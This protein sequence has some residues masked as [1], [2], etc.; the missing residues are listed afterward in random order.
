[1][2]ALS[3]EMI[4]PLFALPKHATLGN[5]NA[6]LFTLYILLHVSL[7]LV[8]FTYTHQGLFL[9]LGL[10]FV[11]ICLGITLGYHRL[12][13]HRSYKTFK[14][15]SYVLAFFG[16]LA[17]QR[18]PIWWTACHRLHHGKVDT[19][20]DPHSP[21]HN[22]IWAHMLWP[23]FRNPELEG[24]KQNTIGLARDIALDPGMQFLEKNYTAIN[25]LFL[26]TLFGAGY[27][28]GGMKLGL[29]F[30][31]WGGLLRIV[32]CLHFT[33]LVNSV[34]H[35][36]GYRNYPT[37]DQSRNNWLVALLTYGE[38]WHNNHHAD[39]RAARNGHF[40]YEIDITY[41]LIK[42]MNCIGLAY[43]IAPVRLKQTYQK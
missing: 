13:A 28:A 2:P 5:F 20:L 38:G 26:F 8:P 18:G 16:C 43:D 27:I 37:N 42:F 29:S 19:E 35:T 15:V 14:P 9:M 3:K 32:L 12:F 10:Y 23:F 39:A 36:W 11:T 25:T 7:L 21:K 24:L 34:S 33:W 30:F 31:V 1:M 40:W 6:P 17:F 4:Q 22:F 41:Y